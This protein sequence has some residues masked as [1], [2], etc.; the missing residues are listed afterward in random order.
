[1]HSPVSS[2]RAFSDRVS[3]LQQSA[4]FRIGLAVLALGGL[5]IAI[6]WAMSLS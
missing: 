4:L 5:W 1:M 6:A 2:P 3:L